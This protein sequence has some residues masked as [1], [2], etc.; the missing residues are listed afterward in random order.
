VK[1]R[2]YQVAM[3]NAH[4]HTHSI[5]SDLI[6]ELMC[7]ISRNSRQ[8]EAHKIALNKNDPEIKNL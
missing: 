6:A 4:T 8:F 1:L 2:N 3:Q 7:V 5:K